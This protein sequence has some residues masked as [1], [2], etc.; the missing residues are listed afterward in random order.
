MLMVTGCG[1]T[2]G[3]KILDEALKNME[4][5]NKAKMSVELTM[6]NN[7]TSIIMKVDGDYDEE[8]GNSYFKTTA[9]VFGMNLVTESYTLKK[10]GKIYTYTSE[11]GKEW[12]YTVADES[13]SNDMTDLGAATKYVNKYKSVKKVKSDIDGHTKLELVIDKKVMNELMA[14]TNE[15]AGLEITKDLVMYVYIKDGYVTKMN[16]DLSSIID[17]SDMGGL[18]KYSMSVSMSDHNKIDA[19]TVPNEV[20]EK[21]VLDEETE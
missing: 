10:D 4:D 21:A 6:G 8:S 17:S 1:N 3:S 11:D 2:E 12:Y 18:T 15:T 7:Q 16:M 19:I 5:V 14:E 13:E 20:I 9:N